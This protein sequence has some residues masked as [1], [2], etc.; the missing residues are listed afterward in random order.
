MSSLKKTVIVTFNQI[1]MYLDFIPLLKSPP[2]KNHS[3]T[4]YDSDY[5][6]YKIIMMYY[7]YRCKKSD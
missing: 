2:Q 7:N 5:N 1:V 4:H 3:I 6:I